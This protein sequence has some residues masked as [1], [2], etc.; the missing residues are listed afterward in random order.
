MRVS[1]KGCDSAATD[2]KRNTSTQDIA[3]APQE[4]S[5]ARLVRSTPT[6]PSEELADSIL[7]VS[8]LLVLLL[9]VWDTGQQTA[10][11]CLCIPEQL[12]ETLAQ[13]P[14]SP[15]LLPDDFF[16]VS[17]NVVMLLQCLL[18]LLLFFIF[19]AGLVNSFADDTC[20]KQFLSTLAQF[21]YLF[22]P[23]NSLTV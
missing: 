14:F 21:M 8:A 5:S 17:H 2:S 10:L 9:L 16:V 13:L 22:C 3:E 20:Q 4:N 15:Y 11:R 1:A 23:W 19:L 18:D 12:L 6:F 7:R